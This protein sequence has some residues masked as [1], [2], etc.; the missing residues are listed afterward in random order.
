MGSRVINRDMECRKT[1]VNCFSNLFVLITKDA[2][3]WSCFFTQIGI[4][5]FG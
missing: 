2:K 3:L 5:K 4:Y 1:I